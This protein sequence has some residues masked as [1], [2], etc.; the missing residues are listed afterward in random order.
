MSAQYPRR[1]TPESIHASMLPSVCALDAVSTGQRVDPYWD[2]LWVP[3]SMAN[4]TTAYG[5]RYRRDHGAAPGVPPRLLMEE[6]EHLRLLTTNRGRV[7]RQ[8]A[9]SVMHA[10]RTVTAEQLAAFTGC[11]KFLDYRSAPLAASFS[12]DLVDLG[13]FPV[14]RQYAGIKPGRNILYRPAATDVFRRLVEPTLTGP[15]ALTVT[16]GQPWSSG[17]QYDRH[18]VLAAELALRAAE[19]LPIGTVM[20]E[21]F[22]SVDLLLGSGLGKTVKKPDNRRADGVVVRTDGLRIAYEITATASRGLESKVRR[23][24]EALAAHPLETAGLVLVFV[25]AP[26][27]DRKDGKN[28]LTAIRNAV[29]NVLRD[30]PGTGI[31]SPAARIGVA[32]WADWFPARHELSVNFFRL[33]ADFAI[34]HGK[35]AAKWVPRG[36]LDEQKFEPWKTFDATAVIDNAP[37]LGATPHWLREA[38]KDYTP[39]IGS[40]M[41]RAGEQVPHPAP[42]K[43]KTAKGRPLGS[44]VGRAGDT[45]L[46]RRLRII[47]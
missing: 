36:L 40:P 43:P 23:W 4:W 38:G 3:G 2:E 13:W 6:D 33:E 16:G 11:L 42:A 39:L 26:H 35:G 7:T 29:G 45:Q 8:N 18:N 22:A 34:G 44:G 31:D 30:F 24:A 41:D 1:K 37:L 12:A 47:G 21:T 5:E 25:A 28:P 27:P 20:G 15:E 9:W 17:G 32:S 10:Y 46:P 19:A 14:P